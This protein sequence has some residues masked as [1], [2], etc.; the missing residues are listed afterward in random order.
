MSIEQQWVSQTTEL[1]S[2]PE[3]YL[4]LKR[5]IDTPDSSMQQVAEIISSDPA[6]TANILKM[7]NS[8]LFGF[9]KKI[10]TVSLALN[11]L[12]TQQVHDLALATSVTSAFNKIPEEVTNMTQF[13][14]KSIHCAVLARL[15][16]SRCN[17]LDSERLFIAGLLHDIGHLVMY[18]NIPEKMNLALQ[19][20]EQEGIPLYRVE[21]KLVNSDYAKV[22]SELMRAWGL[23][24]SLI[25]TTQYQ[26]M[27]TKATEYEL[28][29]AIVHI[30]AVIANTSSN[31]GQ[32]NFQYTKENLYVDPMVWQMTGLS[33]ESIE[34]IYKEADEQLALVISILFPRERVSVSH[35]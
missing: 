35:K 16:A 10:G 25:T 9:G 15:L 21:Q 8:A 28:Q 20:S 14:H 26:L 32:E 33:P 2:L 18:Q 1:F 31:P 3:A 13:W 6:L 17:V 23:P 11:M 12:G 22:G 29:T 4:Q 5:L 24:E 19:L 7:V 30:A 27:P 34:P